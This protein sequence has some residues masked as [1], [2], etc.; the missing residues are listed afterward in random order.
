MT[1]LGCFDFDVAAVDGAIIFDMDGVLVNSE[2][3]DHRAWT[4]LL[5]SL[6]LSVDP[7]ELRGLAGK[8]TPLVLEHFC[9]KA[10]RPLTSDFVTKKRQLF[11]QIAGEGIRE[12]PGVRRLLEVLQES[13]I[14]LAVASASEPERI[15]LLLTKTGLKG[16]FKVIQS[17]ERVLRNKPAPDVYLHVSQHLGKTPGQCLV[18]EDSVTG[19]QAA[20]AAGMTVWGYVSTMPAS[21][22]Q[23]AG[24]DAVFDSFELIWE[25][26]S[27]TLARHCRRTS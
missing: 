7:G 5:N 21:T 15:E 6:G 9:R 19:V 1:D 18:I 11:Y 3:I 16:F 4:Q 26:F 2:S 12:N 22:L 20:K 13:C 25:K 27:S 14:P 17:G 24:A 23:Q 10:N 8:P